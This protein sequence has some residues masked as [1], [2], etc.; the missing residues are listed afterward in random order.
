ML[1][2]HYKQ[3]LELTSYHYDPTLLS[4]CKRSIIQGWLLISI[5]F[6]KP[7]LFEG[8]LTH[9]LSFQ[10]NTD[11]KKNKYNITHLPPTTT[12]NQKQSLYF[13]QDSS[14]YE[15]FLATDVICVCSQGETKYHF[16]SFGETGC[17][18]KPIGL[19]WGPDHEDN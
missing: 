3:N 2:D 11:I 4:V 9:I 7:H 19:G 16:V 8:C 1:L 17:S 6:W 13:F 12:P 10:E 18:W 5:P 14:K 15:D